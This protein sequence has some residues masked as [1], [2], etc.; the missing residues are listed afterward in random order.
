MLLIENINVLPNIDFGH[1][2]KHYRSVCIS[3]SRPINWLYYWFSSSRFWLTSPCNLTSVYLTLMPTMLFPGRELIQCPN[4]NLNQ[5]TTFPTPVC[6]DSRF[7]IFTQYWI[8]KP[9]N[10]TFWLW[11]L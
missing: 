1:L 4:Y 8:F 3:Y 6:V 2:N 5:N 10:K 7:A 11:R 9:I